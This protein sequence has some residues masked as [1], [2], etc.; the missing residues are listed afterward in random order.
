MGEATSRASAGCDFYRLALTEHRIRIDDDRC[1]GSK[2]GGGD[3]DRGTEI[4]NNPVV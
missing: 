1:F 3:F 2:C 4:L